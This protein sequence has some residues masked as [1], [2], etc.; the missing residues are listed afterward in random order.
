MTFLKEESL[1][2]MTRTLNFLKLPALRATLYQVYACTIMNAYIKAGTHTNKNK[3]THREIHT[4]VPV[5][6]SNHCLCLQKYFFCISKDPA[7]FFGYRLIHIFR[8]LRFH[9]KK[10]NFTDK[11]RHEQ[12]MGING[13]ILRLNALHLAF[14]SAC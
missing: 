11:V 1:H 12:Y 10:T 14:V 13:I 3:G 4:A 6:A 9:V 2:K 7:L 5:M 8:S